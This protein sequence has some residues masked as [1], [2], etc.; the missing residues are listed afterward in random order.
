MTSHSLK[1]LPSIVLLSNALLYE[2]MLLS[3]FPFD[4]DWVYG[5][6][7]GLIRACIDWLQSLKQFF[8]NVSYHIL[9]ACLS[10][11]ALF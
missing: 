11:M 10:L 2:H 7:Y 8:I 4:F 6:L 3:Y 1:W 9:V 5:R